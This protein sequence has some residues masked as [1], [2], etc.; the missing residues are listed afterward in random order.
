M[1]E[2][3]EIPPPQEEKEK[4][5][6]SPTKRAIKGFGGK[7]LG[8]DPPKISSILAEKESLVRLV[9]AARSI[10]TCGERLASPD[11]GASW[12]CSRILLQNAPTKACVRSVKAKVYAE[13]SEELL[14]V[15]QKRREN[16]G[17][18]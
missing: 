4:E 7:V 1:A 18:A 14:A 9:Y 11:G 5:K 13:G 6:E 17:L 16:L 15:V 12:Q 10:C 8:E 2:A 3:E